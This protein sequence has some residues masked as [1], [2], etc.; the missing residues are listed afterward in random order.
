MKIKDREIT[1]AGIAGNLKIKRMQGGFPR[2]DAE[3]EIDLH[4][5]LGYMHAHDRQM[6]MWLMKI[7]G[8]GKGS[9]LLSADE[10]LIEIDKFMRWVNLSADAAAEVQKLSD[11]AVK[12]LDAYCRG[13]NDAAAATGRPFEFK[14][15]GYKP[16]QWTP[17]D[18]LLMAKMIGYIG[19]TQSQGDSE[20]FILELIRNDVD[21]E[22]IKELFPAIKEDI[23]G[24]IIDI[25]KKVKLIRPIVSESLKW[26]HRLPRAAASNNWAVRPQKTASGKAILCADPHMPLQM[27]SIWYS[28][29]M[30][31]GDHYMMGAT[32][33]GAPAIVLG[34]TENLAWALTYGTMD[35]IDYF[36][37]EV[38]DKKYRRG[39]KWL[40]FEVREE[41]IRPKKKDPIKIRIYKNDT[42]LLEGEPDENGYYLNYAWSS[43]KGTVAESINNL[44][45]LPHA[46]ST[47]E[48]L[49]YF[50]GLP[51]GP[52]NWV[53]ADT[54]GNIG[55]QL[56]GLYPQKGTQHL[57]A[58]ALSRLG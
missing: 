11:D 36:I 51:F 43:R 19:L 26:M 14:L 12:V 1:L 13:V 49:K 9:E 46:K 44:L 56:S 23:P 37:E 2:I 6:Q 52:F 54:E 47:D 50:A 41:I 42:G 38:Q 5:G 25:I 30:A 53:A 8:Q 17:A 18:I 31:S 40:P 48:A 21:P 3:A 45:K 22:K 28:A 55:Y 34:R 39:E 7:I 20:K 10:E 24:D 33:P 35:M 32:V 57:G 16:D 27:P 29:L 4:Y 58:F 15:M